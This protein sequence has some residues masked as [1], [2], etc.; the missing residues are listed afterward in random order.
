MYGIALALVAA[1]TPALPPDA[2]RVAARI[3]A[4]LH[5]AGE[6]NGDRSARDHEVTRAMRRL[7]CDAVARDA[8]A[9]KRRHPLD[10]AVRRAMDAADEL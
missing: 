10:A 3:E 5:F 1:T 7:H 6:F 4:C 2:A 8:A 9:V